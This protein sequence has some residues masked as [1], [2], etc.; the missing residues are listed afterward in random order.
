MKKFLLFLS[1]ALSQLCLADSLKQNIENL[2]DEM[3][4]LNIFNNDEIQG[5]ISKI[6]SFDPQHFEQSEFNNARAD[7]VKKLY[8]ARLKIREKMT[9]AYLDKNLSEKTARHLQELMR[10]VRGVEDYI[11]YQA[12][13]KISSSQKR[14]G[15]F[16]NN[17]TYFNEH[18]VAYKGVSELS[19]KSGDILLSR[20]SA[21][22][23]GAIARLGNDDTQFSHLAFVYIDQAT[24]EAFTIE[25][26]IELGVVVAPLSKW[27]MDG[28]KRTAIYR[29]EDQTL[30]HQAAKIMYV[31]AKAASNAGRNIP[32]DFSFNM[33]DASSLFCSEVARHGFELA[34]DNKIKIPLFPAKLTPKNPTFLRQ[35]GITVTESFIPA[36]IEIDPRFTPIGEW[37]KFND[38]KESYMRDA[39]MTK[40][41]SWMDQDNWVLKPTIKNSATGNIAYW[42]RKAS[43]GANRLGFKIP[44]ISQKIDE[45]VSPDARKNVLSIML[46]LE[47]RVQAAQDML[48][49]REKEEIAKTGRTLGWSFPEISKHLE[50]IKPQITSTSFKWCSRFFL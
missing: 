5:L 32:Y 40:F 35:I 13:N 23:S 25:A 49:K 50:E 14:F 44:F 22:T 29:F 28:K 15:L 43:S 2:L 48:E 4:H 24:Q 26:H 39:I 27:L 12:G 9:L 19:I 42:L 7:E 41:Y 31:K 17:E 8:Q 47:S 16:P 21:A 36:D 46:E 11:G 6:H 20:G 10:Y 30:A 1:L 18:L 34:S 37:R 3:E 45:K 33:N 38:I